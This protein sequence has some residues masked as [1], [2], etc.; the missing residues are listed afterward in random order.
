MTTNWKSVDADVPPP[1][2]FFKFDVVG[3]AIE[4]LYL[5]VSQEEGQF[6]KQT[7]ALIQT[8]KEERRKVRVNY[9]LSFQLAEVR[10]GQGVRIAYVGDGE[11][12][13]NAKTGELMSPPK[14]FSVQAADKYELPEAP[15]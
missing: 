13:R 4:G 5:G 7:V 15:F 1:A 2:S 8:A 9:A 14:L 12:S 6:G 11:A 3:D 10:K